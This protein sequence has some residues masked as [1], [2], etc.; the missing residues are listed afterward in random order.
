MQQKKCTKCN[1]VK[2]ISAFYKQGGGRN[3]FR[4][5]CIECLSLQNKQWYRFDVNKKKVSA[6]KRIWRQTPKGRYSRYKETAQRRGIKWNLT[7]EQFMHF[8]QTPCRYCGEKIKTV[9]LDRIDNNKGY[10]INNVFPCC[11]DCNKFKREY[12]LQ[13]LISKCKKISKRFS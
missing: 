5:V 3:G 6:N 10:E 12:P 4:A 8:W 7:L 2:D 13:Y 1:K 11:T 9:G